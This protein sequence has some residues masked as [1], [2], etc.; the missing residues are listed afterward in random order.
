MLFWPRLRWAIIDA[1]LVLIRLMTAASVLAV[2]A[3]PV[4][5][6][7][8]TWVAGRTGWTATSDVRLFRRPA[9]VTGRGRGRELLAPHWLS[10]QKKRELSYWSLKDRKKSPDGTDGIDRTGG[11]GAGNARFWLQTGPREAK[12][13]VNPRFQGPSPHPASQGDS[14]TPCAASIHSAAPGS[15]D[16]ANRRRTPQSPR[17]LTRTLCLCRVPSPLALQ[18]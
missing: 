3:A 16:E 17:A 7:G 2:F 1:G 4:G 18:G 9:L 5:E 8:Q 10:G 13:R 14:E 6:Y 12:P 11:S 15:W